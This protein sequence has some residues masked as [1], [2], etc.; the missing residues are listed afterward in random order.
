MNPR[1]ARLVVPA[2]PS[3]NLDWYRFIR[4]LLDAGA[5]ERLSPDKLIPAINQTGPKLG[6]IE[7]AIY[8]WYVIP[9]VTGRPGDAPVAAV[10]PAREAAAVGPRPG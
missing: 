2:M 3:N 10:V 7:E 4:F 9:G 6:R 8:R 1:S 5:D